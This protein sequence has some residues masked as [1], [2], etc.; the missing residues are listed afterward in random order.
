MGFAPIELR[1]YVRMHL[2]SNPGDKEADVVAC[3]QSAL[4]AYMAGK[5][6]SCGAPIWVI[7]SSQAGHMCFTCITGETDCSDDY[8]IDEAC[9]K[10]RAPLESSDGSAE[11]TA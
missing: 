6:C 11:Y 4:A 10:G 9:D 2:K 5:R 8:E 7:G 1:H 3:L